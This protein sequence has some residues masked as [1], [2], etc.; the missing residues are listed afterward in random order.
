MKDIIVDFNSWCKINWD[1]V[2]V[3][4]GER[5]GKIIHK[6][7][8]IKDKQDQPN[9]IKNGR[10]VALCLDDSTIN[11]LNNRP[12][13]SLKIHINVK[14]C[15]YWIVDHQGLRIHE[16]KDKDVGSLFGLVIYDFNFV[17]RLDE[18]LI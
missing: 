8:T 11:D 12:I 6:L 9:A 16:E 3:V 15:I 14:N 1:G 17:C 4:V 10:E 18:R 2:I 7:L 13:G 5:L